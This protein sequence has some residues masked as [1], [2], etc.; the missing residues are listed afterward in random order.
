MHISNDAYKYLKYI[1]MSTLH[2]LAYRFEWI[3]VFIWILI[4]DV[5]HEFYNKILIDIMLLINEWEKKTFSKL[6]WCEM[7]NVL[8]YINFL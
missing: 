5:H 6:I 7:Y 3:Y 8:L 2:G 1:L 4:T